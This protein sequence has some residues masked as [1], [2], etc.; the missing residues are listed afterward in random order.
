MKTSQ[1]GG[2][3]RVKETGRHW[4]LAE[5]ELLRGIKPVGKTGEETKGKTAKPPGDAKR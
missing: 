5:A 3:R 4:D 2:Q 1:K